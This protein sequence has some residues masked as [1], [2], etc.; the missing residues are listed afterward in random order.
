MYA[1]PSRTVSAAQS[2]VATGSRFVSRQV[3][4]SAI[5][6]LM[7][8]AAV[9]AGAML[10]RVASPATPADAVIVTETAEPGLI[11]GGASVSGS[12]GVTGK[13]QGGL[14]SGSAGGSGGVAAR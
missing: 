7:V 13:G 10:G 8:V 12:G 14:L 5:G 9:V 11:G 2:E 3:L 6:V 4:I 1:K